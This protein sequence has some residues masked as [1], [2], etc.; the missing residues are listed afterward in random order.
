MP[1]KVIKRHDRGN[2]LTIVGTVAGQV[3]RRRAQSDNA[4]LAAEEAATIEAEILRAAWHGERR[5]NRTFAEAV[6]SYVTAEPRSEGDKA[7]L[8]RI[9]KAVGPS[10]K[11]ADMT[12]ER[13]DQL[14]AEMYPSAAPGTVARGLIVPVRAVLRHA[15]RRGWCDAPIFETPRQPQGRTAF[16]TP[17][18]AERLILAA[19]PHLKPLIT[20]LIGTGA[21][22]SE[23]L[24]LEWKD[25]DLQGQKA[26]FHADQTKSGARRVV[27]LPSRVIVSLAHLPRLPERTG[28][29]FLMPDGSP[30]ETSRERGDNGGQIKRGWSGAVR[31]AGLPEDLTPHVCRHTWASWHYAV[32]RDLLRLKVEGGW[33]STDLVE[34]YAHLMNSGQE[35]DIKKFLGNMESGCNAA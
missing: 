8:Q 10:A 22:M 18:E 35:D 11:L 13:L 14:R 34:R 24:G 17:L 1:L 20:F 6:K 31:R 16:M 25:V 3:I 29:V 26:T 15:Q 21:R 23:A 9:L 12:Q 32:H 4:K 27:R 7:R 19:A 5:G 28:R 2:A 30:Y 33:S